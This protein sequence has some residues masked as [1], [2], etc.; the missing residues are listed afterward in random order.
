MND[1]NDNYIDI[2]IRSLEKKIKVLD[3]IFEENE[4]QEKILQEEEFDMDA[5]EKSIDVKAEL[6]DQVSFL[7]D[8]F[9]KMYERIKV[10]LDE[11]REDYKEEIKI[12]KDLIKQVTTKSVS[13]QKKEADNQKLAQLQFAHT[14]KKLRQVKTS[15]Q[16]ADQYYKSMS[17]LN[18]VEPQFMD[19]KK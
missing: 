18:Y 6:I 4:I 12:L 17:K 14:K 15:N 10:M 3:T 7:D 19:K 9:E 11:K 5:F 13:V 16:M 8:G 1:N 2:L